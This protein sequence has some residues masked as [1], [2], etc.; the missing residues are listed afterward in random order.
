M[1]STTTDSIELSLEADCDDLVPS[2]ELPRSD[3]ATDVFLLD[4]DDDDDDD[5]EDDDVG[6]SSS[7]SFWL[8]SSS[9]F[10]IV[11]CVASILCPWV[12]TIQSSSSKM[13][14]D[15]FLFWLGVWLF[16]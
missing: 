11:S 6:F 7:S 9:S 1:F 10:C 3:I 14:S 8:S 4:D 5:S 12:S 13:S 2:E 16:G 15:G